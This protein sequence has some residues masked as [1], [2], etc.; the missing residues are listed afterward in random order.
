[1]HFFLGIEVIRSSKGMHLSQT[2]YLKDLI[3][4]M[5]MQHAKPATSPMATNSTLS[6][7]DKPAFEVPHLYRSVV[8]AL[9][10]ATLT[11][12]DISFAVNKVSQF[13]HQPSL[14]HWVAV[15]R[16]IR[17]LLG[18][19]H[20]GLFLS[21]HSP[22]DLHAY[23][24]A[25]WA[26][27]INDRR[28]TSGFCIFIGRNLISWSAKKQATVSRSSTEVEYRSLAI[29]CAELLWLRY[30][31]HELHIPTS[32]PTTLWCDNL[33]ATFLASNPMFHARTKHV[34]IDYHFVRERIASKELSVRFIG[35]DDQL[36]DIMTKPLHS[37][38][39]AAL[40]H[41]LTVV[42]LTSA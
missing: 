18:T 5:K 1:M 41:K 38:R 2:K 21:S 3:T 37:P 28:S 17:Y 30:L 10:Y 6:I 8:G 19:L 42:P 13:M 33:G 35:S 26:G 36:A 39:F 16:I 22:L 40:R 25:D 24:D 11:R 15:K 23:C 4:R 12:P 9:Q 7:H 34:E 32:I 14:S 29:A 27:S 31:L 20:H